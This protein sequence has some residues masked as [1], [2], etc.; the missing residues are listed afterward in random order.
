MSIVGQILL[1]QKFWFAILILC[2]PLLIVVRV[3]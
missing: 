2:M 3:L 1:T